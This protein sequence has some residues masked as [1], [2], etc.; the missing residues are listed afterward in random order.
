MEL[1]YMYRRKG[2][3]NYVCCDKTRYDELSRSPLFETGV[4]CALPAQLPCE[5]RLPPNT[6]LRRGC[7]VQTL[8]AALKARE[9]FA[10]ENQVFECDVAENEKLRGLLVRCDEYLVEK[11]VTRD[12][13]LR[14]EIRAALSQR[15][16]PVPAQDEQQPIRLPER[17][18][19]DHLPK[20][21]KTMTVVRAGIEAYNRALDDVA[22][23]NAAPI[24]QTEQQH[25]DD[26]AVDRFAAAMKA[27]LAAARAKGSGGWGDPNVC[28]VEFLAQLLVEHLAKGNAGTFE[29]VANF[30]MMLHQRGADP[31]VLAEQRWLVESVGLLKT[32]R[33]MIGGA[34]WSLD[35]EDR[36][37]AIRVDKAIAALATQGG[38]E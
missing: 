13:K 2:L 29:D 4:A 31:K 12:A 34:T 25:P 24:A 22:A 37:L 36:D 19:T 10:A 17:K 15:A 23:L 18:R 30:A 32:L 1:I 33:C 28:S 5:V 35:D 7:S 20:E 8:A 16:E 9:D 3:G 21:Y 27:K 14:R 26:A 6:V 38:E 11:G